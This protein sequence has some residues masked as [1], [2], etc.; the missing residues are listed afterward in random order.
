MELLVAIFLVVLTSAIAWRLSKRVWV[1]TGSLAA[2]AG[3]LL[4]WAGLFSLFFGANMALGVL[5]VLAVRSV[6][7]LFVSLYLLDSAVLPILSA[8]QAFLLLHWW[9]G[10]QSGSAH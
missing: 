2:A 9:R 7:P 5:L 6:T 3:A 10:A 4:D 1:G 8:V